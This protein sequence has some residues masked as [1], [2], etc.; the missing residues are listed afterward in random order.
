MAISGGALIAK[1]NS[2]DEKPRRGEVVMVIPDGRDRVWLHRKFDYPAGVYRLMT[3]GVGADE[4]PA[5]AMVRETA[6]ETGLAVGI[7]RCL[8]VVSYRFT[9][10]GGTIPFVSYIFLST[11]AAGTPRPAD[12]GEGIAEFMSVPVAELPETARRLRGAAGRFAEWGAF[13]AVV[14]E[15]AYERLGA[16]GL[17]EIQ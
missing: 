4:S 3:G 10:S 8:A 15:I 7:D 11:A 13:R 12:P 16:R 17:S 1:M 5:S 14:H 2:P 6:E 9:V